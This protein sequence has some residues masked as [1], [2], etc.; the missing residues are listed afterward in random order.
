[1]CV[2]E[3][4]DHAI[5]CLKDHAANHPAHPFFHYVAFIA[6]HFPLHALPE[7]IAKYRDTYQRGWNAIAAE[8]M[9]ASASPPCSPT[10]PSH[11]TSGAA[12]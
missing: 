11:A 6:P 1:M 9:I 7:D 12:Q 3:F 5:D 2:V 4:T 8:A 10:E